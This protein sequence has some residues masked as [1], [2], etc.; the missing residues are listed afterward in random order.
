MKREVEE[1]A[2]RLAAERAAAEERKAMEA[3][4][5]REAGKV[6]CVCCLRGPPTPLSER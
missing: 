4:A 2:K 1:K 3:A 5:Q 6:S